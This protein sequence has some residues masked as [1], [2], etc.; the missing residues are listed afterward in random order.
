M[1]IYVYSYH[2]SP[3]QNA[4]PPVPSTHT[5][6]AATATQGRGHGG[7]AQASHGV[8]SMSIGDTQKYNVRGH[9]IHVWK[10]HAKISLTRGDRA[11]IT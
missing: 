7:V 11:K 3:P 10:C 6:H 5:H 9:V 1:C 8:A 4:P 2:L